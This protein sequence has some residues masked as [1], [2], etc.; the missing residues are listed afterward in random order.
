MLIHVLDAT[1]PAMRAHF[2]AT[3]EELDRLEALH[4]PMVLALNK[5]DQLDRGTVSM[6][7]RR[8]TW[9]PYEE[10]V[11][12]SAQTGEGLPRL[13]ET[14]ARLSEQGLFRLDLMV[15][16]S[17]AGVEAE[18]LKRGRVLKRDYLAEGMRLVVEVPAS[19]VSR[20]QDYVVATEKPLVRSGGN[21]RAG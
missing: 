12:I 7:Q 21:R 17:R 14:L 19:D 6:I 18:V 15:P 10:V 1:H 13:L 9:A 20:F 11:P 2:D 3:N 8:G 16:Y 5:T 4:K